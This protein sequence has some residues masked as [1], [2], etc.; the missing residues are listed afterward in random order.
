MEPTAQLDDVPHGAPGAGDQDCRGAADAEPLLVGRARELTALRARLSAALGGRGSLVLMS[1]EAGIGKTALVTALAREAAARGA[2]V[3]A[4]QGYDLIT[5]LPYG[6]WTKLFDRVPAWDDLPAPP[7]LAGADHVGAPA[8][9]AALLVKVRD[10]LRAA[11]TRRPLLLLL[12]DLHW[13]DPASLDLLR[14]VAR[15]LDTAPILLL[16]TYRD[17]D[18]GQQQPLYALLP[19][20]AHEAAATRLDLRPLTGADLRTLVRER[21]ALG[22][23]DAVRLVAYLHERSGGN[24]F[25]ANELLRRLEEEGVLRQATAGWAL[26]ALAPVGVPAFLWQVIEGRVARVGA[27]AADQLAVAAVIGQEVRLT[28]WQAVSG[29]EEELL[30]D[31]VERALTA[32]VL[33]ETPDGQ[34]VRF[35]HALI[36]EVLYEGLPLPRRR[37]WH[38]RAGEVLAAVA[39]DPNAVAYHF[40]QAGDP[41]ATEWLIRAGARAQSAGNWLA[42]RERFGAALALLERSGADPRE[43][44]WLLVRLGW[45]TMYAEAPAAVAYLHEAE[46]VA[47]ATDDR[48]LTLAVRYHRG[49]LLCA[50]HQLCAGL[51][52]LGAASATLDALPDAEEA[53]RAVLDRLG[54]ASDQFVAPHGVLALWLAYAGRATEAEALA[55][56]VTART[57]AAPG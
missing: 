12:D 10:W 18:L 47:V 28:H 14:A 33:A 30:A 31:V 1:G 16:V 2:I 38:R 44:G 11:A 27:E 36:R 48:L 32:R 17:E 25:F 19:V 5:P 42:A 34:S 54:Y 50:S 8:S 45:V 52:D 22:D 37:R 3:L 46:Q 51:A 35:R 4:G 26:G 24:P 13:A 56:R 40:Q 39:P 7:V 21:Y 15:G 41:R 29:V 20:L 23:R 49:V 9:H 43:P 55:R 6:P 57:G 53:W